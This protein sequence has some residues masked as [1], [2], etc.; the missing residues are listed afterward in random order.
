[1]FPNIPYISRW[2][3][4]SGLKYHYIDIYQFDI[5]RHSLIEYNIWYNIIL[6]LSESTNL[7]NTSY[8]SVSF[9]NPTYLLISPNSNNF[10][11]F[12]FSPK[13]LII[14]SGSGDGNDVLENIFLIIQTSQLIQI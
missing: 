7:D 13:S 5:Y 10:D 8:S 14:S 9:I 2:Y 11:I 1:M 6:S 4:N 3:L 12:R